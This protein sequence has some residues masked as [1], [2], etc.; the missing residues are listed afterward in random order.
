MTEEGPIP[1]VSDEAI[2]V[3]EPVLRRLRRYH[4]HTVVGLERVPR[5]GGGLI[6]VNHS[7][8][9]YDGFLVGGAVWE[10]TGRLPV[11]LGDDMIFKTPVLKDWA[12]SAGIVPASPTAGL[13]LLRDGHL[14]FLAP[15]GMWES[16]RPSREART[17]RWDNRKGFC[18]LVLRAQ[19]PL[20]L[21]A[22]PAADEIFRIRA[23]RLTETIYKRFRAPFP[24]AR[25]IGP[26]M[27][28]RPVQ[29]THYVAEPI[30][31]PPHDPACE[32]EQVEELHRTARRVM[33]ELLSR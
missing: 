31:P 2:R 6:C 29:L 7:L 16:L 9:T 25:G 11:A 14:M 32:R 10:A 30:V 22:C 1:L 26:T 4:R 23:S 15:G 17:V 18:R 33:G 19:V 12:T 20:I 5:V 28:P 24:I 27:I 21:A 13:D 3:M 8:A